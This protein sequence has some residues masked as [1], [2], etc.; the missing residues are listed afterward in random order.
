MNDNPDSSRAAGANGFRLSPNPVT[1]PLWTAAALGLLLCVPGWSVEPAGDP[2]ARARDLA[3]HGH[4]VE[5][6]QLLDQRLAE[7]PADS[8]ARVLHG[9][10][11]S[12]EGRFT[13]AR[14]DLRAVLAAH[15][16]HGDALPALI[17]VEM[18]SDHPERAEQLAQ[19]ALSR[20]P[21][22]PDLLLARAKALRALKRSREA[23]QTV[24]ELLAVDPGNAVAAQLEEGLSTSL[25]HW[26][27][28]IDHSTEWFNDGRS[29]W[30]ETQ[31]QMEGSTSA[32]SV[33]A[34]FSRADRFSETSQ[35]V[36]IDAYPHFRDGTYA[37]INI[38]YSPD[39]VLYPRYRVGGDLYQM[40]GYG[41]ELSGGFRELNFGTNVHIY[42]ASVS[43]YLGDWMFT[44]RVYLTPDLAGTSHSEQFQVRRYASNGIDYWGVRYGYGSSPT[45]VTNLTDIQILNSS[46]YE[47]EIYHTL[48]RR[49]KVLGRLGYSREDRMY[50]GS[51]RHYLAD[52]TLYYFF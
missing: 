22:D 34:R 36:E 8:D 6:L 2:V 9:I 12:W 27:A 26:M 37:Y 41:V 47:T 7:K 16:D 31:V 48:N 4:R 28:S 18:W 25:Q 29:P 11:L 45:E 3:V 19:D 17:N 15:P 24:R 20:H 21:K 51:L 30:Q 14:S 52:A 49:L 38:G 50:I 35:M 40:V 46:S 39:A 10:I 13:E 42:T 1:A 43:K 32:G 44:S 23:L 33:L 5:A